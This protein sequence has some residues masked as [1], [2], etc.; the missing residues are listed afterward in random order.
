MQ[1]LLNCFNQSR[2]WRL[3]LQCAK[4]GTKVQSYK[5]QPFSFLFL[6][7]QC[8]E[9]GQRTLNFQTDPITQRVLLSRVLFSGVVCFVFFVICFQCGGAETNGIDWRI[10]T[11]MAAVNSQPGGFFFFFSPPASIITGKL[12]P[13]ITAPPCC[14]CVCLRA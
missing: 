10:Q 14:Y 2:N 8:D 4:M 9:F 6:F 7:F 13:V 12:V 1:N 11:G 5:R 3:I